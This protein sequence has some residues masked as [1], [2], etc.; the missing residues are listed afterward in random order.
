[1]IE[2]RVLA[3][4]G[5]HA[6]HSGG[7]LGIHNIQ[8]HIGRKLA[9]MTSRTQ[10]IGPFH[11]RRTD[12]GEHR[13]RTQPLILRLVPAV[14]W[15]LAPVSGRRFV[16]EQ[17]AQGCGSGLVQRGS[18]ASFHRFQVGSTVALALRKDTCEQAVYFARDFRMDCSSRFFSWSVQPPRSRSTGRSS[19]IF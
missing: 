4:Q 11:S 10:I 16:P 19:Q 9:L 8:F 1:M 14:A 13:F 7:G 2:G 12:H 17:F 5:L 18:Q 15:Q 3:N 6:A